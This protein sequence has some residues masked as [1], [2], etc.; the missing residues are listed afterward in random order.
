MSA[1]DPPDMR[2]SLYAC[3]RQR[4][5]PYQVV[6]RSAQLGRLPIGR[7]RCVCR[8]AVGGSRSHD[9]P[10]RCRAR[11]VAECQA[12]A[13]MRAAD[14]A[15]L[16]PTA[17]RVAG[18]QD[19]G[20]WVTGSMRVPTMHP[21]PMAA[22][23]TPGRAPSARCWAVAAVMTAAAGIGHGAATAVPH[24]ASTPAGTDSGML[25]PRGWPGS[26]SRIATTLPRTAAPAKAS[27]A[28]SSARSGFALTRSSRLFGTGRT[29]G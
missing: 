13:P 2:F 9:S 23:T 19:R 27:D 18:D 12:P 22:Q 28:P 21:R 24:P 1:R 15:R 7:G 29:L 16:T 6:L 4:L 20:R 17:R 8:A 25:T 10:R 11:A 5:R 14:A 26:W 3:A